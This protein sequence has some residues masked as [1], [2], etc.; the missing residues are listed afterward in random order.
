MG[1][2]Q[3]EPSSTRLAASL[4]AP[5]PPRTYLLTHMKTHVNK[6]LVF[7]N[8]NSMSIETAQLFPRVGVGSSNV[9]TAVSPTA[10]MQDKLWGACTPPCH[11][12]HPQSSPCHLCIW[13]FDRNKNH[14]STTAGNLLSGQQQ[15]SKARPRSGVTHTS[16]GRGSGCSPE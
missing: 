8:V 1:K 4:C 6:Y 3:L 13:S 11:T 2:S 9:T 16:S 5:G 7:S 12:V 10:R 14:L 15:G